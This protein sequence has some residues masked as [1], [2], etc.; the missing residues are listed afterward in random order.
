ML[1]RPGSRIRWHFIVLV[2]GTAAQG[3]L[4]GTKLNKN[5]LLFLISVALVASCTNLPDTPAVAT[6]PLPTP[7][8]ENFGLYTDLD[9]QIYSETIDLKIREALKNNNVNQAQ[10][11]W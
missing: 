8:P 11:L 3:E 6:A 4:S 9:L 7:T 1:R 2:F 10:E 5:F